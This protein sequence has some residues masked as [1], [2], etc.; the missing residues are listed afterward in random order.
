MSSEQDAVEICGASR[1]EVYPA[2]GKECW[3]RKDNTRTIWLTRSPSFFRRHPFDHIRLHFCCCFFFSSR[4]VSALVSLVEVV[5]H[6]F[7]GSM[8]GDEDGE[9]RK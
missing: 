1:R 3:E 9:D 4:A 7:F 6:D 8:D 2:E 5:I